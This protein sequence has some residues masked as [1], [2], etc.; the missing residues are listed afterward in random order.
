MATEVELKYLVL[1]ND[2]S[3]RIFEMLNKE[4]LTFTHQ[5]KQLSNCY[6]DSLDLRLRQMDMGLRVRTCDDKL[7]QTIKTAGVVIAG[8]HQRPEY[9]VNITSLFPQ[10]ELFPA[11]I[12]QKKTNITD[13]QSRLVSLFSTDFKRELWTVSYLS[14]EIEIAFDQGKITS[15]GNSVDI[16]EIELEL[17]SG[18]KSTLFSLAKLLFKTLNLRAGI[19]SKAARGYQLFAKKAGNE[20]TELKLDISCEDNDLSNYFLSGVN[21]GLMQ[22]QSSIDRYLIVKDFK[23][24]AEIVDVLSLLRHGFWLFESKLNDKSKEIRHELNHFMQLFAWVDNA[25]YLNELLNKTGNYRKKIEYSEQLIEQLKLEKRQIPNVNLV[26]ELLHSERFNLLQ[27]Q[28]LELIVSGVGSDWF[29][30]TQIH[31]SL[32]I[33]AKEKLSENLTLLTQKM[34]LS[35]STIAEHYIE[36]RQFL[37]RCL[38]TGNW[39]GGL[40]EAKLREQFRDPWLDLLLGIRELQSLL[41]IRQ[42]LE[43]FENLADDSNGKLLKWQHGKVENLMVAIEQSKRAALSVPP[44]WQF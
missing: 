9:N 41:I 36:N 30:E 11:D 10:L 38:L 43:R 23:S 18:E 29:K 15:D 16:C 13:L 42:Q 7:E 24:L 14:S 6:F 31:D 21:H 17:L 27:T 26:I 33:F 22:L 1:N 12:W 2:V 39:F 44:Y 35:S 19:K 28:L 5:I 25:I 3:L 20:F 34:S 8:L 40:F 4:K 37:R 32:V